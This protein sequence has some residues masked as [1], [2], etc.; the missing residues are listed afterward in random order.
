MIAVVGGGVTGLALGHELGRRGLEYV[1]L[2]ASDRPGGV[3]RSGC[4]EGHVV[5]WGPQRTRMISTVSEL[6]H[7]LAL[8]DE[9]VLAPEGLDLFVYRRERLRRV[10]FSLVRFLTSDVVGPAAKLRLALEPLTRGPDP[11]ERVRRFFERKLGTEL[12]QA[13]AGPL[14]GGLYASDPADM[15]VGLS[16]GPVLAELGVRRSL[17]VPLLR[18]G[19]GVRPPRA[20]TFRRGMEALTDA[21]ARSIGE[22]L[23]LDAPVRGVRPDGA[24]WRLAIDDGGIEA[25]AVV[26]TVPAPDA[27]NLLRGAEPALARRLASLRYNP[28]AVVHLE[29]ETDLRGLGFQVALDEPLALRGVTYN[30]SLF[31]RE[32]LYTTFLGGARRPDVA[33]MPEERAAELAEKEF[34]LCTGY[35]ARTVSVGAQRMPAWDE[36]WRALEGV[37]LPPGLHVAASWWSRPGLPG[38]LREAAAL[39]RALAGEGGGRAEARPLDEGGPAAGAN[40]THAPMRTRREDA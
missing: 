35:D 29:A 18:R 14:Y 13:V 22:R 25:D 15:V 12:Y 9:L 6:V 21:L 19:G 32:R 33:D 40:Q 20:C 23:R 17:L 26:L 37:A 39:A 2:E 4:V 27:A 36:S 30:D 7:Q 8:R 1:V 28:L 16:L 5:D 38:R 34:A 10:P 31:G 11:A 3:I 24:G